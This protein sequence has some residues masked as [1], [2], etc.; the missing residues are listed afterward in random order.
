MA[1]PLQPSKPS[2]RWGS[3]LQQ[4]VAGV[5]SKLDTILADGDDA[6]SRNARGASTYSIAGSEQKPEQ[7]GLKSAMVALPIAVGPEKSRFQNIDVLSRFEQFA[8][9]K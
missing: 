2:S 7:P 4:A 9:C 3:F 1:S 8:D 5:E 6:A